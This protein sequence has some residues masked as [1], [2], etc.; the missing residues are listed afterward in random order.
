[1]SWLYGPLPAAEEA[2]DLTIPPIRET[3]LT[4]E[5]VIAGETVRKSQLPVEIVLEKGELIMSQLP[6]EVV[7][8]RGELI[9]SQLLI[10]L[11]F[12]PSRGYSYAQFI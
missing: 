1:M 5:P 9:M 3:Q 6:G 4:V 8:E 12:V 10:E 2:P 7:L 11:A